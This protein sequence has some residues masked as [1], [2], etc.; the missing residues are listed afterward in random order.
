[1][2][3]FENGVAAAF[4]CRSY[5]G[6][7]DELAYS[8]NRNAGNEMMSG[9]YVFTQNV[10]RRPNGSFKYAISVHDRSNARG[11]RT[12][13]FRAITRA[14]IHRVAGRIRGGPLGVGGKVRHGHLLSSEF[15][16]YQISCTGLEAMGAAF[17]YPLTAKPRLS[18]SGRLG[19]RTRSI[20]AHLLPAQLSPPRPL[21]LCI[22]D[23]R[24][25]GS[26]NVQT[27][28]TH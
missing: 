13:Q 1:V 11:P 17:D 19:T 24:S 3:E 15:D 14:S 4:E 27:R 8:P 12:F 21:W 20:Q 25:L 10:L 26:S 2:H 16:S 22:V 18:R 7:M 6:G 5:R 9:W 28:N 23:M